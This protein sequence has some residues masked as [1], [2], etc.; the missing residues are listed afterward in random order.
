[1]MHT[2][3]IPRGGLSMRVEVE[4]AGNGHV[5]AFYNKMVKLVLNQATIVNVKY[6]I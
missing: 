5:T 1:M 6:N 4:D 3:T 2:Q